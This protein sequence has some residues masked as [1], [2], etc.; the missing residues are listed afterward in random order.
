MN[1][2]TSVALFVALL[3]S[4]IQL[5]EAFEE[6]FLDPKVRVATARRKNADFQTFGEVF[7]QEKGERNDFQNRSCRRRYFFDLNAILVHL[8]VTVLQSSGVVCYIGN[9]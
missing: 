9:V 3:A 4:L 2:F 5:R 1:L 8:S 7:T 6:E